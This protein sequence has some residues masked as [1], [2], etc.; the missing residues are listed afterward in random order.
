M[1]GI[2]KFYI[3]TGVLFK[4][5]GY[6]KAMSIIKGDLKQKL[7]NLKININDA[8]NN[9]S[10]RINDSMSQIQKIPEQEI[11]QNKYKELN[12]RNLKFEK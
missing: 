8:I 12:R 4:K 10:K 7:N 1:K 11:K 6:V 5:T 2:N 9:E 3:K